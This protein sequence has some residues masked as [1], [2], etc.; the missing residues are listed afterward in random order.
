MTSATGSTI[1]VGPVSLVAESQSTTVCSYRSPRRRAHSGPRAHVTHRTRST[2]GRSLSVCARSPWPS[3]DQAPDPPVEQE[4]P[5]PQQRGDVHREQGVREEWAL[6]ANVGGHGA[7]EV[8]RQQ[9]GAEG[10]RRRDDECGEARELHPADWRHGPPGSRAASCRPRRAP[11]SAPCPRRR[12]RGTARQ[13][14][15]APAPSN[16]SCGKAVGRR[17]SAAWSCPP[18]GRER[19]TANSVLRLLPGPMP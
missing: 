6:H 2:A 19:S 5:A 16:G 17:A 7:T 13:G 12:R 1:Q 18:W 4:R 11:L 14:G 15:Q 9:D 10:R 8:P 3:P